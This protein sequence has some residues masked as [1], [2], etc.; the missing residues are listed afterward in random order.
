VF[1]F[2]ALDLFFEHRKQDGNLDT[3]GH[4]KAQAGKALSG[5][6][7]N[8]RFLSIDLVRGR[9]WP[10]LPLFRLITTL[11]RSAHKPRVWHWQWVV[12]AWPFSRLLGRSERFWHVGKASWHHAAVPLPAS[13]QDG[14]YRKND[15]QLLRARLSNPFS[16]N[17]CGGGHNVGVMG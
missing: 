11:A 17:F 10:V 2:C 6:P 14:I 16:V 7:E 9:Q 12:L 5:C 15:T 4:A 1:A 3:F 13:G 8:N